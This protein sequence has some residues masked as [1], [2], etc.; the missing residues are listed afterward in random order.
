ML[1]TRLSKNKTYLQNSAET[2][3]AIENELNSGIEILSKIDK[4]LVTFLG[5]HKTPRGSDYFTHAYK[6]A[7][8]LGQDGFGVLTGGGP[9]IMQAANEGAREAGAPS[10]GFRAG[11]I[12]NEAVEE[13]TFSEMFSFDFLFTRRF[14]LAIKS[15]AILVYPG[16][17]GT[18][19]EMFE[20]LTLIQTGLVDKVPVICV[21]KTFWQGLL[22]WLKTSP[23]KDGYFIEGE[24]DLRL[25]SFADTEEDIL[26]I[27][28]SKD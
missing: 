13:T 23:L 28:N 16:A 9:G 19:N 27:I 4:P 3:K 11:L 24:V 18:F 25:M 10:L 14:F 8:K 7:Y 22:D 6:L 26:K 1:M 2:V 15:E 5:S 20:Y 17:F 12:K 21:G